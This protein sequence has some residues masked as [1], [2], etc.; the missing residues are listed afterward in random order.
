MK[1]ENTYRCFTNNVRVYIIFGYFLTLSCQLK[2]DQRIYCHDR[3]VVYQEECCYLSAGD[4]CDIGSRQICDKDMGYRCVHGMCSGRYN[5]TVVW[6]DD[7]SMNLTWSSFLP[8][9][10]QYNYTVLYSTKFQKDPLIYSSHSVG[11]KSKYSLQWLTP[12]T[13]YYVQVGVWI[14]N[15]YQNLTEVVMAQTKATDHCLYN[16]RRVPI[17]EQLVVDCEESCYCSN[18]GRFQCV[19]VC[20]KQ[21]ANARA[22]L[23]TAAREN[24]CDLVHHCSYDTCSYLGEPVQHEYSWVIDCAENCTCYDGSVTCVPLCADIMVPEN[25][26]DPVLTKSSDG[27]CESY[28]CHEIDDVCQYMN[29]SHRVGTWFQSSDCEICSCMPS[30]EVNCVNLSKC[31]STTLPEKSAICPEP[32]LLDN[33]CC[34]QILCEKQT[35]NSDILST[36]AITKYTV[37]SSILVRFQFI[38]TKDEQAAIHMTLFY[39]TDANN[40][41]YTVWTSNVTVKFSDVIYTSNDTLEFRDFGKPYVLYKVNR[42][43]LLVIPKL[44]LNTFYYVK[45]K[46][47]FDKNQKAVPEYIAETRAIQLPGL[48]V[49][50]PNHLISRLNRVYFSAINTSSNSA[51]LSWTIPEHL[52]Y[53]I[54]SF[55]IN[56]KPFSRAEWQYTERLIFSDRN[57]L[58]KCLYHSR[59]YEA[60]LLAY[61]GERRL[62]TTFFNTSSIK[63]ISN[64]QFSLSIKN[65][66]IGS[67]FVII[68]WDRL[69]THLVADVN[70]I[71]VLWTR[72]NDE[73][74]LLKAC[75]TGNSI[76]YTLKEL[77]SGCMYTVWLGVSRKD[78]TIAFTNRMHFVSLHQYSSSHSGHQHSIIVAVTVAS[79]SLVAMVIAIATVVYLLKCK[80]RASYQEH[81]SFENR[82]FQ[83]YDNKEDREL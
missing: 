59:W 58:L 55:V 77:T 22:C 3:Q 9:D 48:H 63:E 7:T 29:M 75:V 28:E 60:Q 71:E 64:P 68:T 74:T 26:T 14:E 1:V 41:N 83:I 23:E 43:Y 25:C 11:N 4:K 61:P 65:I 52:L 31:L 53:N 69:P 34:R 40:N 78:G 80:H 8:V 15:A 45:L 54:S 82:I 44:I 79:V 76:A 30:R 66:S 51:F 27:C 13:L 38:S 10:S 39:T 49:G 21:H 19:P 32:S 18:T 56:Y 42:N 35:D 57:Y 36:Y 16:G 62:A 67:S 6:T 73:D 50:A 2:C 12:S 81:T 24:C 47:S 33:L 46:I 20:S 17:G 5:L 70:D 37:S 72:E